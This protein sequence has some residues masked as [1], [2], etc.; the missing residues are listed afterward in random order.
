MKKCALVWDMQMGDGKP[1]LHSDLEYVLE[2]ARDTIMRRDNIPVAGI[3]FCIE[4]PLTF[5]IFR[6]CSSQRHPFSWSKVEAIEDNIDQYDYLIAIESLSA[7]K[8]A[9]THSVPRVHIQLG[10][11]RCR[12]LDGNEIHTFIK[13]INGVT[14]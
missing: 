2:S 14:I 1:M 5:S 8:L 7:V 6:G 10:S 11:F 4:D 12:V 13:S 9:R 3:L